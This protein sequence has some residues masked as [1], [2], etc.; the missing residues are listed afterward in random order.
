MNNKTRLLALILAGLTTLATGSGF[1]NEEQYVL[2]YSQTELTN[3]AGRQAVYQRIVRSAKAYCPPYAQIRSRQDVATCV[4]G[5]VEDLVA[6]IASSDFHAFVNGAR[7][8]QTELAQSQEASSSL[9][10]QSAR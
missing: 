6:K 2:S 4:D 5:V 7:T 3:D 8:P 1:A 10:D 9:I